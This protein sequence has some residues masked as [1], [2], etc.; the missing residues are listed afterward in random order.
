M[1]CVGVLARIRRHHLHLFASLVVHYL[2]V[3]IEIGKVVQGLG[4]ELEGVHG[5]S[6]CL[7]VGYEEGHR[8]VEHGEINGDLIGLCSCHLLL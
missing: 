1:R 8:F 2:D 4:Y 3:L 6:V 5:A 7:R